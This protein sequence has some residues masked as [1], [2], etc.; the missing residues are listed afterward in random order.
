MKKS[1]TVSLALL[2]TSLVLFSCASTKKVDSESVQ[3]IEDSADENSK[4]SGD[5]EISLEKV[6]KTD[7]ILENEFSGSEKKQFEKDKSEFEI[8]TA[9]NTEISYKELLQE[10]ITQKTQAANSEIGTIEENT[11]SAETATTT[12]NAETAASAT[13]ETANTQRRVVQKRPA[14]NILEKNE[15]TENTEQTK[16]TEQTA[17]KKQESKK[18]DEAIINSLTE[19]S[20]TAKAE[21]VD[22]KDAE[23]ESSD[24][25]EDTFEEKIT[26]SRSVT[27]KNN[28]QF[29]VEYPGSGWVYLGESEQQKMFSFNGRKTKDDVTVFSLKTRK[30]GSS[31]LHFYK[32]DALTGKYIDDYLEINVT[33][34]LATDAEKVIV[35][36][37]EELV[38]AKPI[39]EPRQTVE[40]VAENTENLAPL[41]TN[42][43]AQKE[44]AKT[45]KKEAQTPA[46]KAESKP[47][48]ATKAVKT[49]T[50]KTSS[51]AVTE[52]KSTAKN[53]VKNDAEKKVAASSESD[54]STKKEERKEE[55]A[56]AEKLESLVKET[57]VT[58]IDTD[59]VTESIAAE[60]LL[61]NANKALSEKKYDDALKYAQNYVA[62]SSR[63]LDE[64]YYILG[65][66]YEANSKLKNIKSSVKFYSK[67]VDN[68]P[69]SK[70]WAPSNN[71]LVYLR[72]FYIDIR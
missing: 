17:Q 51:T 45:E 44:L 67:V 56:K 28:L 71:R 41:K 20:E 12:E 39:R 47:A 52:T 59:E 10:K 18:G 29:D 30:S 33:D 66:I 35:P 57:N 69:L 43:A 55:S 32:N 58:K 6:S 8:Q 9:G 24:S 1:L 2:G 27:L 15:K 65:Q 38:P 72:R 14:Q 4:T 21:K 48:Q 19:D 46:K 49:P 31:I 22:S 23:P 53:D 54:S 42:P 37:Y 26:P 16:K 25:E 62:G 50:A 68:Y 60:S 36:S 11:E 5:G 13:E 61:E 40:Y 70:F 64:A 7:L 34:E 63:N 3:P